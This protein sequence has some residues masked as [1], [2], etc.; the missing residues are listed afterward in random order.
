[1]SGESNDRPRQQQQGQQAQQGQQRAQR[2]QQGQQRRGQPPGGQPRQGV[3]GGGGSEEVRF[4]KFGLLTYAL[5]G[6]GLFL[7]YVFLFL[8]ADDDSAIR[9]EFIIFEVAPDDEL[10][11]ASFIAYTTF[12]TIVPLIAILVGVYFY[13]TDTTLAM[14]AKAAAIA[15][16]VGVV[17]VGFVLLL[18]LVI[19]EPDTADV[20]LGDEITG[21]L[22]ILIGSVVVS[23][24]TGF[25]LENDP[26]N[27]L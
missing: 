19:F 22:G 7:S 3:A 9:S 25:L 17:A 2:T 16:A 24:A 4:A 21:L 23:A 13:R 1:M 10:F 15:T 27:V 14:P 26:L 11:V 6:V 5:A 20:S 12:L 18:F 8:L